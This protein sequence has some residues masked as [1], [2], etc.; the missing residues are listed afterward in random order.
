[1]N[2]NFLGPLNYHECCGLILLP[3]KSILQQKLADIHGFTQEQDDGQQE[4]DHGHAPQLHPQVLLHP[5]AQ[6]PW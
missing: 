1:M 4:E 6:L 3:D 2:P 5:M